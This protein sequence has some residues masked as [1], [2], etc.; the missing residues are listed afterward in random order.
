V[1][2]MSNCARRPHEV[3]L[4]IVERVD[5]SIDVCCMPDASSGT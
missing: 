2:E 1:L 3:N 4:S 5:S